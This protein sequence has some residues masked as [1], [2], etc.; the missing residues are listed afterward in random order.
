MKRII[1]ALALL[2][3]AATSTQA[4]KYFTK[5]GHISFFSSTAME[6]IEAHNYKAN[7]VLDAATGAM[8][9]AVLIKGF[10]FKK[11]L[12]QEHFNENHMESE[13]FPKATFKGSITNIKDVNFKKDGE[14]KVS[15]TGDLTIHGETKKVTT[16][17]VFRVKAGVVSAFAEFNVALDDYKIKKHPALA[18]SIKVTVDLSKL[19]LMK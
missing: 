8:E 13:K 11:A 10:E 16:N 7:A 17:G 12:M 5:T 19:D 15:V 2:F 9:F 14:Y 3:A 4:Q 1:I 6:D 18:K